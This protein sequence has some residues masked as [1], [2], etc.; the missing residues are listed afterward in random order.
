V[1]SVAV[2]VSGRIGSG[3]TTL[4][5]ALAVRMECGYASFG[6]YV[7]SVALARELN[8]SE[9]KVLQDVGDELIAAG[10][11]P[12]CR[13]MLD[14]S[15]YAGGSVV[16]DGIRHR[17]AVTTLAQI[18]AP[19]PFRLLA[20][21]IDSERRDRR[22]RDRG[23]DLIGVKVAEAHANESHVGAVLDLADYT[24]AGHLTIEQSA[25]AAYRML[26]D[27]LGS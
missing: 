11:L 16:V 23:V 15:G 9:R 14:H 27:D 7:R 20:V 22:L 18:V 25:D 5:Q 26:S 24:V 19:L 10:W 1:K 21:Y 2:G 4:A 17:E 13:A 3:K 12:F 8:V 6:D